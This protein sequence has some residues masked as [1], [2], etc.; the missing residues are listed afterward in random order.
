MDGIFPVQLTNQIDLRVM[1]DTEEKMPR[2]IP[3]LEPAKLKI[4]KKS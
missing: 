4:K 1:C 3:E 2:K